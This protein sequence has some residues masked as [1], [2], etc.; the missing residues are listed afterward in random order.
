[1]RTLVLGGVRSGKT[2]H[3]ERLALAAGVAPVY[4]ATAEPFDDG[5]RAR[6]AAHRGGRD[7]RW[8]TVE[9]P[10]DLAA[11]IAVETGPDRVVLVD[12]LTLWLTNV[13]LAGRG[14]A[15]ETAQLVDAVRGAGG[16]LVLVSNEVGLGGIAADVMARRFA[17]DAGRLHQDL[18]AMC[19]TV[20]LV[21]AGL[22]L[23]LKPCT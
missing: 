16:P 15:H 10:L 7:P 11:A 5:M 19:E 9:E 6:I 13:V 1:M 18:A 4:L 22:P 23:R 20:V 17:D 2:A 3:A 8:R 12:C 14:V 21:A